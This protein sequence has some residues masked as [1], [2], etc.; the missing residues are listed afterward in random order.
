M[1]NWTTTTQ[2]RTFGSLN[3][4]KKRFEQIYKENNWILLK[5]K[6]T[7]K[8]KII[9]HQ[10]IIKIKNLVLLNFLAKRKK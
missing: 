6:R 4:W 9:F 2:W 8:S 5:E 3:E 7:K 10:K 1:N